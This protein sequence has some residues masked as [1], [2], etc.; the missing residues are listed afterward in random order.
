[1]LWIVCTNAVE[2]IGIA[3]SFGG[4]IGGRSLAYDLYHRKKIQMSLKDH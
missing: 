4:D 1:M 3:S 2:S